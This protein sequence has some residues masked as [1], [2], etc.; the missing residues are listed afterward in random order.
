[1]R[2]GSPGPLRALSQGLSSGR[3]QRRD[4]PARHARDRRP[5]PSDARAEQQ[6]HDRNAH[7]NCPELGAGWNLYKVAVDAQGASWADFPTLGFNGDWIVVHANVFTVSQG[8]CVASNIYAFDKADLYA[9]GAD[10][11]TVFH[12]P[13]GFTDYRDTDSDGGILRTIVSRRLET[14]I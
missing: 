13:T 9:G 4:Y 11:F 5:E 3:R 6:R 2:P 7:R 14:N 10:Q 8:A 1:M 12:D